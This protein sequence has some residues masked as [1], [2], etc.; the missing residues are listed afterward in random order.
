MQPNGTTAAGSDVGAYVVFASRAVEMQLGW[1]WISLDQVCAF[2]AAR[3]QALIHAPFFLQAA[4]NLADAHNA[5]FDESTRKAAAIWE[6]QL[7]VI[8]AT[9]GSKQ[10]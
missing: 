7:S 2:Q 3:S 9:G 4:Q 1:S 8:V 6:A 10:V 5:T